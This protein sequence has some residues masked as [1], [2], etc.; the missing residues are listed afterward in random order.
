MESKTILEDYT[1]Q[2]TILAVL[3][4]RTAKYYNWKRHCLIVP[5]IF[6]T[7]TLTI[8]NAIFENTN[9]LKIVNV[10]LNGFS[11]L[12]IA[13][14]KSLQYSEKASLFFKSGQLL[15]TLSHSID[16]HKLSGNKESEEEFLK[17]LINNY[18]NIISNITYE[19]PSHIIDKVSQI[20]ERDINIPLVLMTSNNTKLQ[21]IKKKEKEMKESDRNEKEQERVERII[22][23]TKNENGILEGEIE[24]KTKNPKNELGIA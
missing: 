3:C 22:Y 10:A 13:L 7:S 24:E 23:M 6:I 5:N 2:I 18:D 15:T 21:N 16:K 12:L 17:T 11:T 8:L 20:C 9:N 19:I 14:D 1:D 4:S